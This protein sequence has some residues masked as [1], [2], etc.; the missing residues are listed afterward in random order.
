MELKR[1]KY[2]SQMLADAHINYLF[3]MSG[4]TLKG[5]CIKANKNFYESE[6]KNFDVLI[7]FLEEHKKLDDVYIERKGILKQLINEL[8]LDKY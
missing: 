3:R 8:E 5:D 1:K 6:F 2:Y 4:G 7:E